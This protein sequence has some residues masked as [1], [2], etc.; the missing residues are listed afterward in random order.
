[1]GGFFFRF[2][3]LLR[4]PFHAAPLSRILFLRTKLKQKESANFRRL[5]FNFTQTEQNNVLFS[6]PS[7]SLPL[8]FLVSTEI[9]T[10]SEEQISILFLLGSKMIVNRLV[11]FWLF[12]VIV[13]VVDSTSTSAVVKDSVNIFA[14]AYPIV[15]Y[16]LES[17]SAALFPLDSHGQEIRLTDNSSQDKDVAT[18]YLIACPKSLPTASCLFDQ[19]YTLTEGPKTARWSYIASAQYIIP[20]S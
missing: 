13:R 5:A 11:S 18:T 1:M 2:A 3:T 10:G 4:I 16:V 15:A 14:L 9:L 7:V 8:C 6:S 20:S 17:V 19:P 12:S